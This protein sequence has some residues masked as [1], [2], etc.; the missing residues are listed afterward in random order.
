ML[1][2]I[3]FK[4]LGGWGQ[5]FTPCGSDIMK[6]METDHS[7]LLKPPDSKYS[8]YA[9]QGLWREYSFAFQNCS[10]MH[11]LLPESVTKEPE[12]LNM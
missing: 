4:L 3:A 2:E 7:S 9:L 11:T 12:S 5:I 6:E 8:Q 1:L 10:F